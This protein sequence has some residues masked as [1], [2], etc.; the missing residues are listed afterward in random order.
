MA[1]LSAM[2]AVLTA[3]YTALNVAGMTA[4]CSVHNGVPQSTTFPYL[5]TGDAVE[6]REDCMGA[7]GK[8]VIVRLHVFSQARSDLESS[9]IISK[10]VELLHY[11]ALTVSGHTLIASQ[12]Q[13]TFDA[14]TEN[15]GA[16]ET[17][18]KVAEFEITV[19]QTP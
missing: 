4:L 11:S 2:E 14:G 17:R 1:H 5:R 19:R 10:A 16:I 9:R 13:Q 3:V 7:P 18:H 15:V 8:A 12:Y 6:R